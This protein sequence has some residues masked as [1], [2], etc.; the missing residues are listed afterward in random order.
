[1]SCSASLDVT[2]TYS[3]TSLAQARTGTGKTLAFLIPVLQRIIAQN[4][5]LENRLR[6]GYY[7]SRRA[8][9]IRAIVISPTRELAEQIAVEAR[10]VTSNT[11]VIV[12]TAVGG[13]GKAFGLKKMSYEGCHILIATPGR[14]NDILQDPSS[15]IK[16]P[17][18]DAFV[19]DEADRLLDDGFAPEIQSIMQL[20]PSK[21][22]RDRQTLMFSAT[23]PREVMAMVRRLVKPNYRFVQTV[24]PGEQPTHERVPQ[25][26]VHC[27]GFENLL[28]SLLE[29][30]R[31]EQVRT[32]LETPFKA[33]VFFNANSEASLATA[34]F[35]KLTAY[36]KRSPV[37]EMHSKLT[38]PARTR[39][40]DKFRHA[41]SAV[42]FSS[43]VSAR[44][45]D[46]PNVTH[47]IQMGLPRDADTYIHRLGRTARGDKKGEGWLL[48]TPL[49]RRETARRLKGMPL[50]ADTSLEA[51]KI[52]MTQETQT[53]AEVARCLTD[54]VQATKSVGDTLKNT[55]YRAVIGIFQWCDRKQDVVEMMNR[56][57]IHGWGMQEPPALPMA[58]AR[59]I[60]YGNVPGLRLTQVPEDFGQRNTDRRRDSLG[61]RRSF[62]DRQTFEG[63]R[64]QS[65]DRSWSSSLR[66]RERTNS[67]STPRRRTQE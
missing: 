5:H 18:L 47:V 44:G 38:Q 46:F 55:A 28:P 50:V 4:P 54:T 33:I 29:L 45:M 13:T 3:G 19:L 64:S 32:D 53:S 56:R 23:V 27:K 16:A 62:G 8:P 31:R 43:D 49:E 58:L 14:L 1:M 26:L 12:Q 65:L 34:I 2:V 6:A 35:E 17:D 42:M 51:A 61:S 48:L 11:G 40:S 60:G 22:Q 67:F 52:D 41:K 25:K 66:G 21:Q 59:K 63:R 15:G 20:L 9:D 37:I 7:G 36:D 10:R 24:Q 30:V 39:N 57:A